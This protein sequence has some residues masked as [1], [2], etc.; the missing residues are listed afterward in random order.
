MLAKRQHSRGKTSLA[1]LVAGAVVASACGGSDDGGGDESTPD[2][3]GAGVDFQQFPGALAE[4][5]PQHGGSLTFSLEASTDQGWCIPEAQL[6]I[7][8]IQV[9]RSVYDTL[10]VPDGEGNFQPHLA[11]SVE[12][13]DDYTVWDITL[14]EG[15]E[16]H[17]SEPLNAEVVKNNLD[18]ATGNYEGRSGVLVPIALKFIDEVT[19]TGDLTL[20]VT[21]S[22]PWPALDSALFLSGRLGIMAQEQL[23][24]EECRSELIGTGPF[25]LQNWDENSHEINLTRNENYWREDENGNQLP[26]LDEL[27]YER[28]IDGQPRANGLYDGRF[29][30]IHINTNTEYDLY[31]EMVD[32]AEGGELNF[33]HSVE[34][35][36]VGFL[37]LNHAEAPFDNP[38]AREAAA[39]A[40]DR[41]EINDL[42]LNNTGVPANGPFPPGSL[43]HAEDLEFAPFDPERAADLVS[44]YEEETGENL[45]FQIISTPQP[46]LTAIVEVTAEM[47]EEVG[48]TVSTT[49]IDQSQLINTAVGGGYQMMTFRNYPGLDPDNL[50]VWWHSEGQPDAEPDPETGISNTV[51]FP[52][53]ND[54]ELDALLDAGRVET[55]PAAREEIYQD[56]SRRLAEE[57]HLLWTNWTNWAVPSGPDVYGMVGAR[58]AD[59]PDG[60]QDY[61]GFALGVDPALIWK[62]N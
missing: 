14:R 5:D 24:H 34:F 11:E 20:Q 38:L 3:E 45:E 32:R 4:D 19:V 59:A 37:M 2:V 54:P 27:T 40:V 46:A 25:E 28:T 47:F 55:D 53:I 44:Q 39:L 29:D 31:E 8:G 21:A 23:D 51:N 16:F 49:T 15:I 58:P 13:N 48:M 22:E 9:A 61:T 12:P 10:T 60:S 18:A 62:A 42:F 57:H 17:N 41:A 30:A 1:L 33:V 52:N 36:E 56:V 43:G 26:Y 35:A 6:A 50:R 7:S